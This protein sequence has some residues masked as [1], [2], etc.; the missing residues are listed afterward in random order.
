[1]ECS[2]QR[3]SWQLT[4]CSKC[5]SRERSV[6][7]WTRCILSWAMHYRAVHI[8]RILMLSK[9]VGI[10]IAKQNSRAK[11]L[12]TLN[13]PSTSFA[14]PCK[15][16]EIAKN[17]HW[18]TKYWTSFANNIELLFVDR[19][20]LTMRHIGDAIQNAKR[21]GVVI[22]IITDKSMLGSSNSQINHLQA[23][24]LFTHAI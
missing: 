23:A 4:N 12:S 16:Q 13:L 7:S 22:R 5:I 18:T 9:S 6:L 10:R 3:L 17:L 14:L 2:L 19:Y 11:L 1:M 15:F 8:P 21:R 20:M 24:G